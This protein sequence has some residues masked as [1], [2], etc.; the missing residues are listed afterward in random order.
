[1]ANVDIVL[2]S[3]QN[4][5]RLSDH[6]GLKVWPFQ[7]YAHKQFAPNGEPQHFGMDIGGP[8]EGGRPAHT[9][10]KRVEKYPMWNALKNWNAQTVAYDIAHLFNCSSERGRTY[11]RKPAR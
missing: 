10:Y 2:A 8:W 3:N 11:R 5:K 4:M 1:M 6:A 7:L 9:C